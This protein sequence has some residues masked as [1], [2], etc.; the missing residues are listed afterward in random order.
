M[1]SMSATPPIA[2]APFNRD[3]ADVILRSSDGVHFH[4]YA[5]ILIISSIVFT[6]TFALAKGATHSEDET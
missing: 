4:L 2:K 1:S 3:D 5:N 6:D